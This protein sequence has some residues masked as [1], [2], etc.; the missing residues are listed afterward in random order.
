MFENDRVEHERVRALVVK[1]DDALVDAD[2]IRRH[3]DAAVLVGPQ[4]IQQILRDAKIGRQGRFAPLGEEVLI[5]TNVA[6]H[7]QVL[8]FSGC[9]AKK[10][11][12][13]S[14]KW[15]LKHSAA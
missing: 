15:R 13:A 1:G 4:R 8:L 12:C 10:R 11:L 3:T 2:H 7:G 6:D 5:F 14:A 9:G